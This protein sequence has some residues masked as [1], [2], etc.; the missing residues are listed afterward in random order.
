MVQLVLHMYLICERFDW[1]MVRTIG[2]RFDSWMEQNNIIFYNVVNSNIKATDPTSDVPTACCI[3]SHAEFMQFDG[4]LY[5]LLTSSTIYTCSSPSP[6]RTIPGL[7][8]IRLVNWRLGLQTD[9]TAH[10]LWT[11][12]SR[13]GPRWA[14]WI[15]YSQAIK[16]KMGPTITTRPT[17]QKRQSTINI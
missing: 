12:L 14:L 6:L 15:S 8:I 9:W 17:Q 13:T 1:W 11:G 3:P 10:S 2:E 4:I 5:S 16:N 7:F